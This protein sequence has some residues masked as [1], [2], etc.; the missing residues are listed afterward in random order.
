MERAGYLSRLYQGRSRLIPLP[1]LASPMNTTK[2]SSRPKSIPIIWGQRS[3]AGVEGPVIPSD[4]PTVPCV[5]A[6]SEGGFPNQ[7]AVGGQDRIANTKGGHVDRYES[8]F[9]FLLSFTA[10]P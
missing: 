10:V 4:R 3:V 8:P 7:V 2:N 1:I 5:E 9:L 6:N